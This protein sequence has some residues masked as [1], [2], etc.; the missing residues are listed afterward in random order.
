MILQPQMGDLPTERFV[1]VSSFAFTQTGLDCCGHFSTKD[2]CRKLQKTYFAPFVCFNTKAVYI[3]T[4][5]T[6]TKVDCLTAIE[7][8][9]AQRGLPVYIYSDNLG[10]FIGTR[11][12]I[13]F[14]KLLVDRKFKELV[15]AFTTGQ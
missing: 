14:R 4:V 11:G 1:F 12:E 13:E 10:T 8:F 9:S 6:L 3:E 7:R 5:T 2:S 15:H